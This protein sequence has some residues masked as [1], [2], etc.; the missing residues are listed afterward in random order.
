MGVFDKLLQV[1]A[2]LAGGLTLLLGL[3]VIFGWY[4]GNET[5]VQVLPEFVPMQYNTALGFVFCGAGLLLRIYGKNLPAMIAGA[6]CALIGI[7][8]LVE[9]SAGI[10]LGIDELFMEHSITV[11]TSNPGR[12]A[13]GAR[14]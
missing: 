9:Y 3:V 13:S 14:H 1:I 4:T 7:L 5:L 11:A 6:V 10:S 12:M 8:T 2:H